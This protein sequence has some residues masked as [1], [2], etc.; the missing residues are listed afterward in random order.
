MAHSLCKDFDCIDQ[1]APSAETEM[2]YNITE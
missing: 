2:T 1:D